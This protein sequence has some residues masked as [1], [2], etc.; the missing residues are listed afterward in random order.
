METIQHNEDIVDSSKVIDMAAVG[1]EYCRF[2]EKM[3]TCED[4]LD[5]FDFL[6]KLLPALYLKGSLLP[7]IEVE[8]NSANERFVTEEEYEI[9][10]T[11]LAKFIGDKDFFLTVPFD[12]NDMETTPVALSELLADI[13][14]DLKDFILLLSKGT[15]NAKE[16]AVANCYYYFQ[17]G[18][19]ERITLALPYIHHVL[20]TFTNDEMED[21]LY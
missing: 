8:D 21:S 6:R 16:N 4:I 1:L 15:Q 3:H 19:G 7:Y 17:I 20:S 2:I 5:A 9:I 18:W 10:R 14:L 13:Y 12:R 11:Q